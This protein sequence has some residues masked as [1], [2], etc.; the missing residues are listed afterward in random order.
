VFILLLTLHCLL[1]CTLYVVA[2]KTYYCFIRNF[3]SVYL[4]IRP[5]LTLS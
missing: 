3:V 4:S 5:K 2:I 1:I